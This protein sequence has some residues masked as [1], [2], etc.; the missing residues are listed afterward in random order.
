MVKW[1]LFNNPI[2]EFYTSEELFGV[3][4]E[5]RPAIKFLP[6]WFKRI[7]PIVN[8]E[9]DQ[10]GNPSSSAKACMPMVD[11]MSAGFIIPLACDT[12]FSVT[13]DGCT[14]KNSNN[15]LFKTV[16]YH[17]IKQL[18]ERSAP[19]FPTPPVKWLNPWVIKTA[20]GWSVLIIS[21]IN[22]FNP[23]FTCLGGFVDTDKYPKE[24]NLPAIWHTWGCDVTIPAG[25]PLVQVIPIK[26]ADQPKKSKPRAVTKKEMA[27][28]IK[29]EKIQVSRAHY[30]VNELRKRGKDDV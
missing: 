17:T 30:Y 29:I 10:Y 14:V 28:K 9:K 8:G 18:G 5:P 12:N 21:P 6:D 11:A 19:G 23:H 25:T 26:R 27:N 22:H 15:A 3:I 1:N 13:K 4:P 2:I 16:D 7:P 24:I 20:P